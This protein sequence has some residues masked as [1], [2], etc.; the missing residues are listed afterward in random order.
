[1]KLEKEVSRLEK[2]DFK[3]N[4]LINKILEENSDLQKT[5]TKYEEDGDSVKR[6]CDTVEEPPVRR[7][8]SHSRER[9]RGR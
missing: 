2:E 6:S 3:K 8:E 7:E 9:S 1:M 4:S 5:L